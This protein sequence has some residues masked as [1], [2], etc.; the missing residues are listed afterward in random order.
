M[1]VSAVYHIPRSQVHPPPRVGSFHGQAHLHENGR[2]MCGAI[3]PWA[4]RRDDDDDRCPDCQQVAE[5]RGLLW[6]AS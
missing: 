2:A 4:A 1:T 5:R 6:P 3:T